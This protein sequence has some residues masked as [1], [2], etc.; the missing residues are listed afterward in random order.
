MYSEHMSDGMAKNDSQEIF[1]T[2]QSSDMKCGISYAPYYIVWYYI[3]ISATFCQSVIIKN[4]HSHL[5]ETDGFCLN[6]NILNPIKGF[7]VIYLSYKI[8]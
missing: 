5:F 8:G 3:V 7:V 1:P 4:C 2:S 6:L